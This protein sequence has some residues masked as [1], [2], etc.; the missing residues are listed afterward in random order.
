MIH[1]QPFNPSENCSLK[2]YFGKEA[3]GF[4]PWIASHIDI[5]QDILQEED[6]ALYKQEMKVDKFYVDLAIKNKDKE[7]F[8][9][10][11]QYGES[12]HDHL[13]KCLVYSMLTTA[14]KTLWI[15]EQFSDEYQKIFAY[16]KNT[17][18]YLCKVE[19]EV[20][21]H[22]GYDIMKLHVYTADGPRYINYRLYEHGARIERITKK[23]GR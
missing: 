11:N 9:V 22:R 5:I 18:L 6:L 16:I 13:G 15:A 1:Q 20:G 2:D 14:K 21:N 19:I 17:N 10:E 8:I 4:T 7:I 23:G 3:S 12:D